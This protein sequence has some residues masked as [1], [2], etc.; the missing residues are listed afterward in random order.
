VE[1]KI[2]REDL[3]RLLNLFYDA[4]TFG[5]LLRVP[6][7]VSDKLKD[8]TETLE[9]ARKRD[10]EHRFLAKRVEVFVQQAEM[11]GRKYDC[12][13]ANPPYMGSKGQNKE[14][15]AFA[16]KEF[17]DSKSDLFAMFIERNLEMARSSGTVALVTMQ[18]WMFLSSFEKLRDNLLGTKTITSMAH[19]GPRGFDTISGEVVQTTAFTLENFCLPDFKGAYLRLVEG[20]S[21]SEKDEM[22]KKAVRQFIP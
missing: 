5:S 21:E 18:S 19:I 17:S 13:V 9:S 10:D 11:L 4:K 22:L 15:K 7:S 14:L 3:A 8:F 1:P 20:K 12:V 2:S 6:E 16:K